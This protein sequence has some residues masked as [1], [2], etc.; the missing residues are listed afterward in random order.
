MNPVLS[1]CNAAALRAV[2][3]SLCIAAT[4]YAMLQQSMQSGNSL[5]NATAAHLILKNP[6]GRRLYPVVIQLV[7][8]DHILLF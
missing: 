6:V 1:P 4:I 7:K 5:C 8:V 2:L 3:Q